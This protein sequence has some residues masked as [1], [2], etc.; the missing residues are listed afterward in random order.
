MIDARLGELLLKE[1]LIES[2]QLDQALASQ[3]TSGGRLG[4]NLVEIGAIAEATNA[5]IVLVKER[6]L[7]V[8]TITIIGVMG[9]ALIVGGLV[10]HACTWL[11][12]TFT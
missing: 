4:T 5:A 11:G 2:K 10:S 9:Y 8:A 7:K 6:G 3:L 12:V 1:Q